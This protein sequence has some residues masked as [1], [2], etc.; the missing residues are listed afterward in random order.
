MDDDLYELLGVPKNASQSEI[1]AAYRRRA[2]ACHPDRHPNDPEAE[3]L[4]KDVSR[5]Y[6]ILGDPRRRRR[7]DRGTLNRGLVQGDVS[8]KRGMEMFADVIDMLGAVFTGV[9]ERGDRADSGRSVRTTLSLTYEEA[10]RGGMHTVEYVVRGRCPACRGRGVPPGVEPK[11]CQQCRGRGRLSVEESLWNAFRACPACEGEGEVRDDVCSTCEGD[12]RTEGRERLRLDIPPGVQHGQTLRRR[13]EGEPGR[14]GGEPGDLIVEIEL[15]EHPDF[16]RRGKDV[17]YDASV[18]FTRAALGG[19]QTVPTLHGDVVVDIP[20][21]V[22]A[23]DTLRLREMGFPDPADGARGHQYVRI[24]VETPTRRD[25]V[26]DEAS[27]RDTSTG[28]RDRLRRL[29]SIET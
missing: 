18:S 8:L 12:G 5:A 27:E 11:T 6:E 15:E 23:G 21:G 26:G 7:Y 22:T 28:W 25:E 1:K 13:G 16:E 9:T 14:R 29:W 20:P 19:S 3:E 2:M 17:Y 24:A 4:F 10:A